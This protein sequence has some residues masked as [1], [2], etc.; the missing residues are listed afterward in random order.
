MESAVHSHAWDFVNI[1]P[2]MHDDRY[3]HQV[4]LND[5]P[6]IKVL[7]ENIQPDYILHLAAQSLCFRELEDTGILISE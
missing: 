7:I 4:D 2:E 3:F 6:K 5:I 1:P